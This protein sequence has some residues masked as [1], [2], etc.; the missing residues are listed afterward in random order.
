MFK[1][2]CISGILTINSSASH[3]IVF[4]LSL[5]VITASLYA[6]IET[7]WVHTLS[8]KLLVNNPQSLIMLLKGVLLCCF[9]KHCLPPIFQKS[10]LLHLPHHAAPPGHFPGSS[11]VK[12]SATELPYCAKDYPCPIY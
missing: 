5:R 2:V 10:A 8:H 3:L 7:L 9:Y 4:T 12:S 11:L 6:T 1:H